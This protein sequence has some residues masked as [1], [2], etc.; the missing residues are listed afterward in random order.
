MAKGDCDCGQPKLENGNCPVHR[1]DGLPLQCVGPWAKEKHDYLARYIEATHAARSKYLEPSDRRSTLGG[2]AY[3]DVFAGPGRARI[4]KTGEIIDG[5]PLVAAS[6]TRAPFTKLILCELDSENVAAPRARTA[7]HRDRVLIIEGNCV[8][9]IE[10]IVREVP[11]NGLNFAL[12][13]PFGP[14]ML[15]W[16]LLEK[17]AQVKRMDLLIHFPTGPIKRNFHNNMDFDSMVG[18]DS[19]RENVHTPHDVPTLVDHLRCS[20]G[21]LGYTGANV[22]SMPIKNSKEGVLYHL[23]FATKHPLGDKIWS[24][25]GKTDARGQRSLF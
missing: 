24:S 23:V 11:P 8:A 15:R 1:E 22:R 6:H 25:I 20:L 10:Q 13:D 5:S 7:G 21:R 9:N 19:W 17:L 3:I 16:T 4:G 18:T 14:T 2:A 12:I